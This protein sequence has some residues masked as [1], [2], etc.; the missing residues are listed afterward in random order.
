[1]HSS[2][3]CT[4]A[5]T[6]QENL[7]NFLLPHDVYGVDLRKITH[8]FHLQMLSHP[9]KKPSMVD[10]AGKKNSL[11]RLTSGARCCLSCKTCGISFR[12]TLVLLCALQVIVS[13]GVVWYLGY[14]SS[15]SIIGSLSAE[16]RGAAL[17]TLSS[18][19]QTS[20]HRPLRAVLTL[21]TMISM[22]V[23]EFG[24]MASLHNRTG[25]L[26]GISA[27]PL[28]FPDISSAG[29]V[30]PDGSILAVINI[31]ATTSLLS[32]DLPYK[33]GL[34]YAVMDS[35]ENHLIRFRVP[36]ANNAWSLKAV[37]DFGVNDTDE[38]LGAINYQLSSYHPELGTQFLAGKAAGGSYAWTTIFPLSVLGHYSAV[39][40]TK[41]TL[42][43][44]GGTAYVCYASIYLNRLGDLLQSL[45]PTY[46]SNG[47]ALILDASGQLLSVSDESIGQQVGN[48]VNNTS[49]DE[50]LRV[51]AITLRR[52]GLLSANGSQATLTATS[53]V[54][55]FVSG[56]LY[57]TSTPAFDAEQVQVLGSQ[58]HLQATIVDTTGQLWMVVV[59]TKDSDFN[60]DFDHRVLVVGLWSLL[61]LAWAI[62]CTMVFAHCLNRPLSL[63]VSYMR[64]VTDI[65]HDSSS[66]HCDDASRVVDQ[67]QRL[68]QLKA[69]LERW[70]RS[71]AYD[72]ASTHDFG[73]GGGRT[74]KS[75][76]LDESSPAR[77]SH[78]FRM[79]VDDAAMKMMKE[80]KEL[81]S[82]FHSMLGQLTT[83][84]QHAEEATDGKRLFFRYIFHEVR[85]PLNAITLGLAN[86]RADANSARSELDAVWTEERRDVLN[87]VHEQCLVVGRILNDVL[88]MQKLDDGAMTLQLEP[89]SLESMILSTMQSFQPSIREKEIQFTVELQSVQGAI[90][91]IETCTDMERLP[92]IDVIGDK[93]RLRQVLANFLSN[94][95]KFTPRRGS[96][97][98]SLEVSVSARPVDHHF[99]VTAEH[100]ESSPVQAAEFRISVED[101]GVGI[102]EED[103]VGLYAAYMQIRPGALQKGSGTGLGLSISK[104]LI[105]LHG[106]DVGYKRANELGGS[107]FHMRVPMSVCLRKIKV[108]TPLVVG[109]RSLDSMSHQG[110]LNCPMDEDREEEEAII[111]EMAVLVKEQQQLRQ[112]DSEQFERTV[113]ITNQHSGDNVAY[114][115]V[116]ALQELQGRDRGSTWESSGQQ[117]QQ[118][119]VELNR[120]SRRTKSMAAGSNVNRSPLSL[121]IVVS[122]YGRHHRKALPLSPDLPVD[123]WSPKQSSSIT[124]HLGIPSPLRL[125]AR[126]IDPVIEHIS[127]QRTDLLP[128]DQASSCLLCASP[129][130]SSS[131]TIMVNSTSST[132]S[133]SSTASVGSSQVETGSTHNIVRVLVA[134]DS[135]P[136]LKLLLMLLRRM[137]VKAEGVEDGQQCVDRFQA[138]YQAQIAGQHPN[139]S[140]YDLVLMDG[141][142]PVMS[143]VAATKQL[144][145]MGVKIP[146]HA[147]TGNALAEDV[148]EFLSAGA[149]LPVLTKPVQQRDLHGLLSYC[150][151]CQEQQF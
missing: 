108:A 149:T 9:S 111:R 32:T 66:P 30:T 21:S 54:D 87:I 42:T 146:I 75:S 141:N 31:S 40:A 147:V 144:R 12:F 150:R 71:A 62:V 95:I 34:M 60:G 28:A 35:S 39:S 59:I 27:V 135:V 110:P 72:A 97:H 127:Q 132:L 117:K 105:Q 49:S 93:Y 53:S 77:S 92:F 88:S 128:D 48:V 7:P 58:Y 5:I 91:E 63:V 67:A 107:E 10:A 1:M 36:I 41:A 129:T 61:V 121:Q 148:Q 55:D 33:Q 137:N 23:P 123:Q 100:E 79:L 65:A 122:R 17:G 52:K 57:Y 138:W 74:S 45:R 101:S 119:K 37:P 81:R 73:G 78:W 26:A 16:L 115:R 2:L 43:A 134:E 131:A 145:A 68:T 8:I 70:Q 104:Q 142:M 124:Q 19:I 4:Y 20:L 118:H 102:S 13:V 94:A 130:S 82:A 64:E 84:M 25:V 140:P 15:V 38:G 18:E 133:L 103:Q 51:V 151:T 90:Y 11:S 24:F 109:P 46:G 14:A 50:R 56:G 112:C 125:P 86:L 96:I 44:S 106:G 89:F 114:D 6:S 83:S 116:Q 136:N 47:F 29:C 113:H 76:Q 139:P 126:S 80:V 69:V 98:V 120:H 99:T 143:G 22:S 3:Q 85:V